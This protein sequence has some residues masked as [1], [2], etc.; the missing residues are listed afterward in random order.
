MTDQELLAL[1][2]IPPRDGVMYRAA[3]GQIT[4]PGSP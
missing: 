3:V 4:S 2:E 1:Y